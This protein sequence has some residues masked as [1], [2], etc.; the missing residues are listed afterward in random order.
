M[1]IHEL[2]AKLETVKPKLISTDKTTDKRIYLTC[3]S[4]N[5]FDLCKFLYKDLG[6]RFAIATVIDSDNCFE[7]LY[8]F[9][10]DQLGL[11][12]TIK[13]LIRDKA[14][15]SVESISPFLPA[16]QWIER[17]MHDVAGIE[18]KNH[19]DMRRLILADDW[20]EGVYP[21]RKENKK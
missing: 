6:C 19:P 17:E 3:E 5:S 18:F 15:P 12:I 1:D 7:I 21:L 10:Y 13:S 2:N 11:V 9:T 14:K 16:A 20:P 4:R 8:H